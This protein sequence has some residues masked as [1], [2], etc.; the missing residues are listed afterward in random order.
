MNRLPVIAATLSSLVVLA[1]CASTANYPSLGQRPAERAYGTAPVATPSDAPPAV[2][3]GPQGGPFPPRIT[4]ARQA[5]ETAHER[6]RKGE[7]AAERL[8]AAAQGA[9]PESDA[10]SQAEVAVSELIAARTQTSGALADLDHMLVEAAEIDPAAPALDAI[11]AAR[12][13]VIALVGKE[14]AELAK[15]AGRLR[16]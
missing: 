1:G 14:D 16:D 7:P 3:V 9:A 13:Q 11:G 4:A 6:F 15:V 8:T 12:E 5:A 10:W 2:A